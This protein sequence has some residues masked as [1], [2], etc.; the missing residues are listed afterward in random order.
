MSVDVKSPCIKVCKYDEDKICIGCHRTMD[1]ITGW[2]FMNN[3]SKRE[4]L[5]AA[6]E[7]KTTPKPGKNDY[8]YYV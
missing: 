6:A 7:R 5:K 1:E 3:D 8:D 4:S 2:L